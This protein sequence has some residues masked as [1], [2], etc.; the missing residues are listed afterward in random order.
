MQTLSLELSTWKFQLWLTEWLLQRNIEI[1]YDWYDVDMNHSSKEFARPIW[2]QYNV[3]WEEKR[4]KCGAIVVYLL[5]IRTAF[6]PHFLLRQ[7][8]ILSRCGVDWRQQKRKRSVCSNRNQPWLCDHFCWLY[9]FMHEIY[10]CSEHFT[11]I[12]NSQPMA[13]EETQ[14]KIDYTFPNLI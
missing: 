10:T 9:M 3:C 14:V 5:V 11:F 1:C 6:F 4:K 2:V 13:L 8:R 7:R 12:F